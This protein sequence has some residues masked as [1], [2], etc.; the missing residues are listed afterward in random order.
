MKNH[1]MVAYKNE[2]SAIKLMIALFLLL[3]FEL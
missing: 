1:K 3:E 2:K